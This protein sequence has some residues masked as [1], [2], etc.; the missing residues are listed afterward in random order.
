[1]AERLGD[2]ATITF[3]TECHFI[4]VEG[5]DTSGLGLE[6]GEKLIALGRATDDPERV[7]AGHDHRVYTFWQLGDRSGLQ[8]EL[9]TLDRLAGELRQ[10]A[11]R[12]DTGTGQTMLALMEGRFDDAERLIEETAAVGRRSLAWNAGVT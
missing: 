11:Q 10:P 3:A 1:M 8:A 5:P 6:V 7:F 2:P 9:A 12:W 4:A